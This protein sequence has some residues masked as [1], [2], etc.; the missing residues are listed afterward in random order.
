MSYFFLLL[1]HGIVNGRMP[2]REGIGAETSIITGGCAV[3]L[4]HA[5]P[6]LRASSGFGVR[7]STGRDQAYW[8][9]AGY[10]RE[11]SRGALLQFLPLV[12]NY[13]PCG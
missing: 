10:L 12:G 9:P 5:P 1:A 6:A 2:V 13:L 7:M 4:D 3:C 8:P 11:V